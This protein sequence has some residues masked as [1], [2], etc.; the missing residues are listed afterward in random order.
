MSIDLTTQPA[1][2]GAK[3]SLEQ[4]QEAGLL[5]AM[6]SRPSTAL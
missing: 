5:P 4:H 1:V 6:N 3:R 2:W